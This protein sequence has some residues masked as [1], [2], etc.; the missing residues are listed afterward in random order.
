M[1]VLLN[2]SYKQYKKMSRYSP[3]PFYYHS[4]DDKYIYGKTA[5]LKDDTLYTLYT[6]KRNDTLDSLALDFYNN[7]TYYWII[8]SFNHIQD[9]FNPLREGQKLKIPSLSNI[10]FDI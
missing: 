8:C 7:P 6:V 1:S 9:P 5:Y 2:K 3:F 4:K 10:E